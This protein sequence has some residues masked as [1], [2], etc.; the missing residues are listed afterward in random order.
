MKQILTIA[1]SD[2]GGGAGIQADLKTITML[3]AYGASVITAVTA[4]NTLGVKG[5][6]DVPLEGIENQIDTVCSDFHFAA[7][8]TGMLSTKEV[9]ELVSAKIKE[10]QIPNAVVDPVM[11]ATSGDLLLHEDAI[12]SVKEYMLP[13]ATLITPNLKEAEV[14]SGEKIETLDDMKRVGT[15]LRKEAGCRNVLMKGGHLSQMTATDLLCLEDGSFVT[16]EG[17]PVV[18]NNTHGTGCTLS[19]ALAVFLGKGLSMK[20]AVGEAKNYL[21]KAL[22]YAKEDRLGHG[23][24]PVRHNY[25]LDPSYSE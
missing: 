15:I 17:S 2:S 5:V 13:V 12:A 19:S 3:G 9:V 23:S 8:K 21:T 18:T 7:M 11:V 22:F 1:G 24:G 25:I 4:Q 16:F 10:Y 14:L 6:Y 20:D